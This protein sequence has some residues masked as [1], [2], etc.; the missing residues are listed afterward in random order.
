MWNKLGY[1]YESL[2]LTE[3]NLRDQAARLER[4]IAQNC[5]PQDSSHVEIRSRLKFSHWSIN[6]NPDELGAHRIDTRKKEKLCNDDIENIKKVIM[7]LMRWN[8]LFYYK[9]SFFI[10]IIIIINL[11]LFSLLFGLF[12]KVVDVVSG[13]N[14]CYDSLFDIL[15]FLLSYS[16]RRS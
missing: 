11:F 10:C 1:H 5:D 15:Y 4:K 14:F 16:S 3:Q 8:K 2:Y 12:G 13:F 7:E 6:S 9:L